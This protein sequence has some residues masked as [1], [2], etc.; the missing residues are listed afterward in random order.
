MSTVTDNVRIHGHIADRSPECGGDGVIAM[1]FV[2]GRNVY[3]R[4]LS[5]GN[6]VGFDYNVGPQLQT[7]DRT[8]INGTVAAQ[9]LLGES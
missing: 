1:V 9:L 7:K 8:V 2:N 6:L 3:Q 4:S 5:A